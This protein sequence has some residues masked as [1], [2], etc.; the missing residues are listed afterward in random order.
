[1]FVATKSTLQNVQLIN[2]NNL[3][4]TQNNK[5]SYSVQTIAYFIIFLHIQ[6]A[7]RHKSLKYPNHFP[8]IY[9]PKV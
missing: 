6:T 2:K 4:K 9:Y 5:I 8:K 7:R 3:C 1:M